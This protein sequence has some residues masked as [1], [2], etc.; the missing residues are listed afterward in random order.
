MENEGAQVMDYQITKQFGALEYVVQLDPGQTFPISANV[1]CGFATDTYVIKRHD[2]D[3]LPGDGTGGM[4]APLYDVATG[5][6]TYEKIDLRPLFK[7]GKVIDDISFDLQRPNEL[8]RILNMYNI[9]PSANL[10]ETVLVTTS[11]FTEDMVNDAL[12]THFAGFAGIDKSA[13]NGNSEYIAQMHDVIYAQTRIYKH[14]Q[15][16]VYSDASTPSIYAQNR[17]YTD[18]VV[19]DAEERGYPN[20]IYCPELTVIRFFYVGYANRSPSVLSQVN[21]INVET[22]YASLRIPPLQ[23]TLNGKTR[24]GTESEI[25]MT[26]VNTLAE[27]PSRPEGSR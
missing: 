3:L 21:A 25:I 11:N 6:G 24:K 10:W 20:L 15:S 12:Q 14:D 26:S 16:R 23:I 18:F 1:A 27:Q 13:G 8:P 7:E 9:D 5:F 22:A 2:D 17:I 19:V 4:P